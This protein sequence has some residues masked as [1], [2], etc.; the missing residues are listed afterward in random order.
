MDYKKILAED[1]KHILS[2]H[3]GRRYLHDL[4]DFCGLYRTSMTGSSE[5]FFREGIRSAGLKILAD[6]AEVDSEAYLLMMKE[7]KNLK[8]QIKVYKERNRKDSIDE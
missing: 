3:Q 5:T 7:T 8:E 2:T 1:L 4:L 6:I